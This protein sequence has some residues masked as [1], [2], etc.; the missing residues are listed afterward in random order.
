M[1]LTSLYARL[2]LFFEE[3]AML[4]LH[5]PTIT[6]DDLCY[7]S[8]KDCR[9]WSDEFYHDLMS[10]LVAVFELGP[11]VT[12]LEV[13]CAAGLLAKGISPLVC[14][15]YGVDLSPV[16][17]K[18][19]RRLGLP[20]AKFKTANG[21]SLPFAEATFDRVLCY[22]VVT[23]ISDLNILQQMVREMIRVTRPGGL[24]LIGSIFDTQTQAEYPQRI[25]EVS[26]KLPPAVEDPNIASYRWMPLHYRLLTM[27]RR[28][29]AQGQSPLIQN[30]YHEQG[31][32]VGLGQDLGLKAEVLTLHPLNPYRGYR[33]NVLY[34]K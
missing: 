27:L 11:G 31:F 23:N 1:N 3:R 34:R 16:C 21:A 30:H 4:F 29:L 26:E 25:Q 18:L 19:A 7:I 28:K 14:E 22:D 33:Y 13:G 10:W 12:L 24:V 9:L 20:N 2:G 8:G 6:R 17:L 5:K 15:Y 32:F